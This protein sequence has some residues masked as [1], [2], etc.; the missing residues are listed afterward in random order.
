MEYNIGINNQVA[1]LFK[2]SQTTR[3][4]SRTRGVLCSGGRDLHNVADDEY[5]LIIIA[6]RYLHS[7]GD[8]GAK[9]KGEEWWFSWTLFRTVFLF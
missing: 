7:L 6:G 2:H 8:R 5:I 9:K 4:V 3:S 1:W